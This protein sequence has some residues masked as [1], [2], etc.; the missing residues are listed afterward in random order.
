[1]DAFCYFSYVIVKRA[2]QMAPCMTPTILRILSILDDARAHKWLP[3]LQYLGI[4]RIEVSREL[5]L[6]RSDEATRVLRVTLPGRWAK[7]GGT[8]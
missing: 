2:A 3:S 1:M 8:T 4:N 5:G 6:A 7:Q